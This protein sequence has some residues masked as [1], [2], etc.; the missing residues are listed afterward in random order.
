MI[1]YNR[2]IGL[3]LRYY[4][5]IRLRVAVLL[6]CACFDPTSGVIVVAKAGS[7]FKAVASSFKVPSVAGAEATRFATAVDTIASVA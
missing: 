4:L 2:L 1:L 5:R 3:Q 7:L 6:F